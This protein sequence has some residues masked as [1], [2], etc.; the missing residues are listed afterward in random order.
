MKMK[1]KKSSHRKNK[2]REFNILTYHYLD[3]SG[4]IK[5]VEVMIFQSRTGICCDLS[6]HKIRSDHSGRGEG[7]G[8]MFSPE[9]CM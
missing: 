3:A 8:S 5:A 4:V 9:D 2:R 6:L 7:G 1:E